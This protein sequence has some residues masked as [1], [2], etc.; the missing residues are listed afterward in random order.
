MSLPD[1]VFWHSLTGAHARF[2]VGE[3]RVRRYA[4]GFSPLVAFEDPA[5]PDVEQLGRY[6]A[7]GETVYIE[8]VARPLPPGWRLE[9]TAAM[10][11]MVWSGERIDDDATFVPRPLDAGNA[12]HVSQALALAQ[13]TRPGPFGPRTIEL[14][15]YFGVFDGER[16]LAMA[17]ER[18]EVAP[19]REISG[20]CTHPSAQGRGLARKLMVRL[21]ARERA[22]GQTPFL[23]VLTHNPRAHALYERMGYVRQAELPVLVITRL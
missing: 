12:S 7:P 20:V 2:A 8:S 11:R 23:H 5:E 9:A 3:G 13:L 21:M 10:Y 6:C 15:E 4:P 14:G 22:R 1:N 17:G 19:F 18:S 16:L